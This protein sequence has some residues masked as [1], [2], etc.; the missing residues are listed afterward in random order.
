[1]LPAQKFSGLDEQISHEEIAR[2]TQYAALF[3]ASILMFLTLVYLPVVF[4]SFLFGLGLMAVL[5]V[6]LTRSQ[7]RSA[8]VELQD[9]ARRIAEDDESWSRVRKRKPATRHR[10]PTISFR[11]VGSY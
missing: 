6:G 1:M 2:S 10:R 4:F 3:G 9:A 11:H 8:V 5:Y 7:R